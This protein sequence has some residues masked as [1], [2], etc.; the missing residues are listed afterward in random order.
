MKRLST[1]AKKSN[2]KEEGMAMVITLMMGLIP[3]RWSSGL[4][5]KDAMSERLAAQKAI[6]KWQK[7]LH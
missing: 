6:N 1:K 2:S 3:T 5:G 7:Q 4:A